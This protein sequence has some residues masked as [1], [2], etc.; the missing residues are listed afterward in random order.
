MAWYDPKHYGEE[1][2]TLTELLMAMA[3]S[4]LLLGAMVSTFTT[5]RRIYT[6]QENVA[7]MALNVRAALDMMSR[8]VRMAGYGTPTSHVADWVDWLRDDHNHPVTLT[9]PVMITPGGAAPDTLTIIGCFDTPIATVEADVDAG[10]SE[11][12][13][14]YQSTTTKLNTETKKI[15]YIGRHEN[16]V[17]TL[18]PDDKARVNTITIDTDPMQAGEQGLT[19]SYPPEIT[20]VELLKMV[21]YSVVMDEKNY[22]TPTPIL[23][24]DE[25]TG[26]HA[27]PLAENI[28]DLRL[29]RDGHI[30][31][32]AITGRTAQ[33]DP[34]YTHPVKGDGYRRLTLSA[35]LHLRNLGR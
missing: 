15:V 30:L 21:T 27:Q 9:S 35:R 17:V 6:V 1:G 32:I 23:K 22:A 31:T 34:T 12:Q 25:H 19:E 33:P 14:R 11:M 16:A 7:E 29:T 3:I 8:E 20:P 2:L 4:G 5:Q 13:V 24:R 26:G 28:E 10:S 18:S